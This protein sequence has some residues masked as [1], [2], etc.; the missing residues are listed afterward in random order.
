MTHFL[1]FIPD[2]FLELEASLSEKATLHYFLTPYLITT[3]PD[4]QS[5]QNELDPQYLTKMSRLSVMEPQLK[6]SAMVLGRVGPG[7]GAHQTLISSWFSGSVHLV[8]LKQ[9]KQGEKAQKTG[10]KYVWAGTACAKG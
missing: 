6:E 4:S 9:G 10:A 1:L 8:S 5:C 2:K 7:R 3:D